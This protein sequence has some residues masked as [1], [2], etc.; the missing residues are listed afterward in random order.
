MLSIKNPNIIK[1]YRK[2]NINFEEDIEL[3]LNIRRHIM[4][5][6]EE[7]IRRRNKNEIKV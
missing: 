3:W 5:T 4:K 7:N 2:N 1:F 6:L